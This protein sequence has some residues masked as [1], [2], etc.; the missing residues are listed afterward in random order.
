M[1]GVVVT[2]LGA[3]IVLVLVYSMYDEVGDRLNK[4]RKAI[5]REF[6]NVDFKIGAAGDL[7]A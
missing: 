4:R 3:V 2:L 7:R 1:T 5:S 6:P